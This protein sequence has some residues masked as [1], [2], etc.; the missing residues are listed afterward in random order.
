[1]AKK[2]IDA[3]TILQKLSTIFK[4][5]I[6]IVGSIY[7]IGGPITEKESSGVTYAILTP[8]CVNAITQQFGKFQIIY[9]TDVK[10][11]K[12]SLGQ[13][14]ELLYVKTNF[15]K[16]EAKSIL[17]TVSNISK[18]IGNISVWD[19]FNWTDNEV[20]ALIDSGDMMTLFTD[21]KKIPELYVSKVVFPGLAKNNLDKLSYSVYQSKKIDQIYELVT[22]LDTEY[23]QIYTIIRYINVN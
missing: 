9:F 18:I 7:A 6:Y 5:D 17:D 1:M 13:S 10:K 8:E 23:F 20:V 12:S 15:D 11:A 3:K 19:K 22:S 4:K 16:S 14:E 2:E 21:N